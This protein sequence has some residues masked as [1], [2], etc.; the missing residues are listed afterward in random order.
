MENFN[1]ILQRYWGYNSFRPLQE[2]I[3]QSVYNGNDTLA[4][5][6]TGG[7]K[8]IC[9]QIPAIAK[10]GICLVIT[11]LIALM[12]DQVE[13]LEKKG[14]KALAVHSGMSRREIDN[15]LEKAATLDYKFLY[16]SPERLGTRLFTEKL[17]GMNI[18]L[19]AVDEAHCI[20]QWGYDFRPSYMKISEVRS[21]IPQVP[22]LALTATATPE[23][24]NDIQ[25]KLMFRKNNLL[26]KSFERK[27]L[28]YV[29]R[30][31]EDKP[32]LLIK[33]VDKI[34][35][36][37]VVYVR[38][39]Q[40]AKD[41]AELLVSH[42]FSADYYHAG[43]GSDIRSIKQD[44]W[45]KGKVRIMVST[46]A[47]G[48]GIDKSDVRFVIHTDLPDSP[49]AYFQEAGRAGR[50]EKTAFG[51]LLYSPSD[52][53]KL[54]QR[55]ETTFPPTEEVKSTYHALCNYLQLPIGGGKETVH[56]FKLQ[57]FA[58]AYKL[59]AL[60]VFNSLKILEMEGYLELTEE[61]DNPSKLM[62]IMERNDLYKL[63]V[64]NPDLDKVIKL[65]LRT[66]PGLFSGFVRIEEE[67]LAK[68]AGIT[69][70][71]MKELIKRLDK[72]NV[73]SYFQQKRTPLLIMQEERLDDK[74]LR[75]SPESY[76]HR[77][78]R[79]Q[80]RIE[81]ML[82]Y[83]ETTTKCR[84]QQLLSYFGENNSCRCGLCDVCKQRNEVDINKVEFDNILHRIKEA[85]TTKNLTVEELT[86][87]LDFPSDKI[88]KVIR[89]LLDHEKLTISDNQL[90]WS[91]PQ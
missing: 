13:N 67:T 21:I 87:K 59:N 14:I 71:E 48:M 27:N 5:L 33:L 19:L 60:R 35:G 72:L 22:I 47:F 68:R 80:N 65:L 18:N 56:D 49:E 79:Y 20:S 28:V 26:K 86:D 43:L 36:S 8:S 16:L 83:V 74:T 44:Q 12:K 70:K 15:V 4:L 76:L 81:A 50:D 10:E 24:A 46:N 52:K 29:V 7:G 2:E 57:N 51:I 89:W 90:R 69:G 53:K 75:I 85:L 88:A 38:N 6:P 84:S 61:I 78:T 1:Q 66:Y 62:F 11:P 63:Q 37:G 31:T 17:K 91:N 58:T 30:E 45:K 40:S 54:L 77:K 73:V 25:E 55:I 9:F 3:I 39:R 32:K 42:G 82:H 41:M 34:P 64:T 23:V